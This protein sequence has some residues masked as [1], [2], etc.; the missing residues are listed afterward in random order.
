[1]AGME[2]MDRVSIEAGKVFPPVP[3]AARRASALGVRSHTLCGKDVY[4]HVMIYL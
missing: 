4:R 1:M 3:P 2:D